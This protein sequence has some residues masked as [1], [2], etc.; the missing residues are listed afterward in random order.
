MDDQFYRNLQPKRWL[1]DI[2]RRAAKDK[3]RTAIIVVLVIVALYLLVDNKG[4]IKRIRLEGRR[5]ELIEQV[6]ADS[7]ETKRLQSQIKALEG[8]RQTAE[9]IA[10]E[11]YGM[12]RPGE[13][14]YKL[15][16]EED[17]K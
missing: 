11:K 9:K 17:K 16:K 8:D 4:I 6:H 15:K 10:R 12:A 14:V 5:K 7:A 13:T 3:R 2:A 1:R